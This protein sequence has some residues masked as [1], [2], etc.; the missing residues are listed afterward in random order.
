MTH[1]K[2]QKFRCGDAIFA[3][4]DMFLPK[5]HID[6]YLH[7]QAWCG[8]GKLQSIFLRQQPSFKKT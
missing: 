1:P 8:A 3:R 6:L 5:C 4:S 2:P 7:K